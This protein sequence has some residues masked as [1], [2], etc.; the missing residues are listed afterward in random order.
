MSKPTFIAFHELAMA[1][2]TN[3]DLAK[4]LKALQLEF[5]EGFNAQADALFPEWEASPIVSA[6]RLRCARRR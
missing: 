6:W 3:P 4:I 5:R 1:S 2:R